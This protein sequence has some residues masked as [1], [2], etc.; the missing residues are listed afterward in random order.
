MS[1]KNVTVK[2]VELYLLT[3]IEHIV[4][5]QFAFQWGVLS[6]WFLRW[7]VLFSGSRFGGRR[8]ILYSLRLSSRSVP[9]IVVWVCREPFG[10]MKLWNQ[11]PRQG[12]GQSVRALVSVAQSLTHLLAA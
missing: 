1:K 11:F 6:R 9:K 12:S 4:Q 2:V 10:K 5:W 8:R 3:N 7:R